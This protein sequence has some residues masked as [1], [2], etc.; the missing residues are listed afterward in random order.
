MPVWVKSSREVKIT[1]PVLSVVPA[2][3]VNVVLALSSYSSALP[4]FGATV[5]V[6][7]TATSRGMGSLAR[8]GLRSPSGTF[9][10]TATNR[11]R[12]VSVTITGRLADTVP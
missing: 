8:I 7:V 11:I 10:T 5:T 12:V 6:M 1:S 3:I 2:A 9:S 4:P